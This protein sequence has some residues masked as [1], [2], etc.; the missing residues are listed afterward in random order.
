LLQWFQ[1]SKDSLFVNTTGSADLAAFQRV[2]EGRRDDGFSR[3]GASVLALGCE[4]RTMP[5]EYHWDGMRRAD[6]PAHPHV[7]FQATLDGY[8]RF[9][10][11]GRSWTVGPE[12]GFFAVLPSRHI[13]SLPPASPRWSFFWFNSGHPWVVGRLAQLAREHGPVFELPAGCRLLVQSSAFFERVCQGR[14]EDGFAE[15]SALLEWMLEFER[16]L[17][18]QAHPRGRRATMLDSLRTYTLKNLRRSFGVDE[19]ARRQGRSRS[20]FSH[21]FKQATGLAPAAFVLD[22]RLSEARS[23]LRESSAPLKEISAATGFADANHFCK[24]FRRRYHLSPGAY[25]RQTS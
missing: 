4:T 1:R 6:D 20:H 16:H 2:F 25:R 18:D 10:R 7:V 17:H 15:E 8:G 5:S 19:Y 23:R 21:A 12:S 24:A 11:P 13:Y 14:F 22:V 3:L 9:E